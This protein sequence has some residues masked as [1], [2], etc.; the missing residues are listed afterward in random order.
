MQTYV[1]AQA[2]GEQSTSIPYLWLS[3]AASLCRGEQL[4][5]SLDVQAMWSGRGDAKTQSTDPKSSDPWPCSSQLWRLWPV[6]FV[7]LSFCRFWCRSRVHV[8]RWWGTL[9]R[10]RQRPGCKLSTTQQIE[11]DVIFDDVDGWWIWLLLQLLLLFTC[12]VEDGIHDMDMMALGSTTS[13]HGC[14]FPK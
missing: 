7:L 8:S 5:Q 13:W 12:L 3:S 4:C 11:F 1:N 6:S 10:P 9:Q 14:F 2:C